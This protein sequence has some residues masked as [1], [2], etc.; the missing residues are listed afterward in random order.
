M[1]SYDELVK[2]AKRADE[3]GDPDLALKLYRKAK[4]LKATP[5]PG[6]QASMIEEAPAPVVRRA[7]NQPELNAEGLRVA[8]PSMSAPRPLMQEMNDA[9][10]VV[11]KGV[12]RF[13]GNTGRGLS[14]IMM[15]NPDLP[16]G[17]AEK[18]RPELAQEQAAADA[19]YNPVAEAYPAASLVGEN[20]LP[21]AMPSGSALKAALSAAAVAGSQYKPDV[22]EQ[23]LNA[24]TSG[25]SAGI[26]TKA[27]APRLSVGEDAKILQKAGLGKELTPGMMAD[28]K[29]LSGRV[30]KRT[31][32]ALE[33]FPLIGS[34]VAGLR[35]DATNALNIN[36][37]DNA[38]APIGKQ[39]PADIPAGA[40]AFDEGYKAIENTYNEAVDNLVFDIKPTSL[41]TIRA[42]GSGNLAP[43]YKQ[44][45]TSTVDD[46]LHPLKTRGGK[47]ITGPEYQQIKSRL[48]DKIKKY[49]N[50]TDPADGD[51]AEQLKKVRQNLD[52]HLTTANP[53]SQTGDPVDVQARFD[54]IKEADRAFAKMSVLRDA[55]QSSA[56][57]EIFTA[58]ELMRAVRKNTD[59]KDFVRG[60]G[61]DQEVARAAANAIP[62][63]TPN[64][65]TT[66]RALVAGALAG[67]AGVPFLVGNPLGLL[68][69]GA[70]LAG[71]TKLGQKAVKN[72]LF[73]NGI[74][75]YL[76]AKAGMIG[77]KETADLLTNKD[78]SKQKRLSNLLRN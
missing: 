6:P 21:A 16:P 59:K 20:I 64:S 8:P 33:S 65:G 19:E 44:K 13:L 74:S 3:L 62:S 49:E 34:Q 41:K 17:Y 47:T 67:T 60:Q 12:K 28:Q 53:R 54:K 56:A 10:G 42:T 11:L 66:D 38:L 46:L 73:D 5:S 72:Y 30:L 75:S 27:L 9:G 39:L 77:G 58:P 37:I 45:F 36:R 35:G 70:L 24:L 26:L 23:G 31:E 51:V 78:A 68:L 63:K 15:E 55:G 2:G 52:D 7:D 48:T 25:A 4:T 50:S 57:S 61:F 69:P 18:R 32:D 14:N 22:K 1:A 76:R 40:Q 29:T 71:G 43:T